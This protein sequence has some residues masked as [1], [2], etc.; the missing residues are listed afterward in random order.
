MGKL[1][2]GEREDCYEVIKG[3]WQ[4]NEDTASQP[5]GLEIYTS[6]VI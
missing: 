6:K 1:I 2:Q 4:E 3:S 5:G